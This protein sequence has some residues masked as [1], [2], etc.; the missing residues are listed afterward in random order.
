MQMKLDFQNLSKSEDVLKSTHFRE[1]IE[2]HN[3]T[4]KNVQEP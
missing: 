3:R 2:S 4:R 1:K